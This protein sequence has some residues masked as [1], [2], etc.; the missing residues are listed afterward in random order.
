MGGYEGYGVA[1]IKD[2]M[3]ERVKTLTEAEVLALNGSAI[4]GG[5][6]P[7]WNG[8]LYYPSQIPDL[9]CVKDPKYIDHTYTHLHPRIGDLM[10]YGALVIF[11]ETV[12][13]GTYHL[14]P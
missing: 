5:G 11:A 6:F 1:W 13:F 12:D 14:I 7:R 4:R 9:I 2:D 10:R 8:S 3:N